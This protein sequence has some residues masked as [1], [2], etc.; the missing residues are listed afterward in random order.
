MPLTIQIDCPA[1]LG[2]GLGRY[3]HDRCPDCHGRGV[4]ERTLT[5]ADLR[6]AELH[7][8][9]QVGDEDDDAGENRDPAGR[10]G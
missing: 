5:E 1:C 4:I 8:L 9:D 6:L 3:D 2:T 7:Q 10:T